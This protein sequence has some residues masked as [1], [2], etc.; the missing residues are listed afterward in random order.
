MQCSRKITDDM[1]WIGGN[2]RRIALFENVFPVPRGVS[3]NSYVVLDEKT[4]L[5]DTVDKAASGIF[6]ENLEYVLNGR[7]LDYLIVNHIEPDHCAEIA[8]VLLRYP[9]VK[10]VGNAKTFG[11]I[12]QFF[13]FDVDSSSVTVKEGDTL[14]TGKHTFTFVMVPMVHWPEVMVTYDTTDKILYSADAF[15][16]FGAINGNIFADEVSFETE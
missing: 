6:F 16:T 1:Y 2:D 15:G 7:K 14:N 4:V 8:N 9:D 13:D 3:Y 5:L 11:M 12:K 10:I